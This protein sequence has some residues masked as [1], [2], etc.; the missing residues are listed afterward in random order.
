MTIVVNATGHRNPAMTVQIPV[1]I[2][3]IPACFA[4]PVPK[5]LKGHKVWLGPRVLLAHKVLRVCRAY[6]DPKARQV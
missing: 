2:A 3:P 6:P 5:A 1:T 4:H